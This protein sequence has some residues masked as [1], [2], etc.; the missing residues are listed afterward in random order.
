[1]QRSGDPLDNGGHAEYTW[2][3]YVKAKRKASKLSSWPEVQRIRFVEPEEV[4][5]VQ[6]E[7]LTGEGFP[8]TASENGSWTV[9]STSDQEEALALATY[10]CALRYPT[11]LRYAQAFTRA[12]FITIYAYYRDTLI[13]CLRNSGY[14]IPEPPS[15][16]KFIDS[17]LTGQS[18]WSP[19]DSVDTSTMDS[20]EVE[21]LTKDCPAMPSNKVLYGE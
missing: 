7:C 15:E 1:M 12:Q 2:D 14:S 19:Y 9:D 6:A 13:P 11:E 3:D 17:A 16:E 18:V 5:K 21:S 10:T 8:A 4:A 20:G